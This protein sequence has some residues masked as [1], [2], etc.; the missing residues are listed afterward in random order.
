MIAEAKRQYRGVICIH[1]GQPIP[2][3]PSA[4]QKEREFREQGTS[5]LGEFSVFSVTLRCRECHKEAVY[6]PSNVIDLDGAPRKR[7][8]PATSQRRNRRRGDPKN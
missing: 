1:C 2:L 6:T 7:R 8:S 3:S 4:E 5:D